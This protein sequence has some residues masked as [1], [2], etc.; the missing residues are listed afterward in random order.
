MDR[1]SF[2]RE[3]GYVLPYTNGSLFIMHQK[4][5]FVKKFAEFAD[6]YIFLKSGDEKNK[7]EQRGF[8]KKRPEIFKRRRQIPKTS[9][10]P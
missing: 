2:L 8:M 6:N 9:V 4:R 3:K 1:D 7:S 5:D 10:M